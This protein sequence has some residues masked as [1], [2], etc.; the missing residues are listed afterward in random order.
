MIQ[1]GRIVI[2]H[3]LREAHGVLSLGRRHLRLII[4]QCRWVSLRLSGKQIHDCAFASGA[5]VNR[6]RG[7]EFAMGADLDGFKELDGEV[8][9]VVADEVICGAFFAPVECEMLDV[10]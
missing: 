4:L 10:C 9:A 7:A 8:L 1:L 3:L 5:L 6:K 2:H